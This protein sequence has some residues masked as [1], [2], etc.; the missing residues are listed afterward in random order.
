MRLHCSRKVFFRKKLPD[1]NMR[2]F[3]ADV[4]SEQGCQK[5]QMKFSNEMIT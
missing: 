3:A 2:Q 1:F 5:K 4:A